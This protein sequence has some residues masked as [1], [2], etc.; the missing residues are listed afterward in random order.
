M[1]SNAPGA[2]PPAVVA[3]PV[4]INWQ[5]GGGAPAGPDWRRT[6]AAIWRY[7]W[8]IGLTTVVGV[9]AGIVAGQVMHPVYQA[10]ATIWID[11]GDPRNPGPAWAGRGDR[12]LGENAWSD[13][14]TSFAVLE[15]AVRSQRLY[16]SLKDPHDA[17]AFAAFDVTPDVRPGTYRLEVDDNGQSYTLATAEGAPLERGELGGPVGAR[18]GFSWAPVP[19]SVPAGH[20]IVFSV[21]T[22][23]D[24]AERL[25]AGLE[26]TQD[27]A[28]SF[29]R[30][31]LKGSSPT[32][33][34]STLNAVAQRFVE[35][36]DTLKRQR[37]TEVRKITEEQLAVAQGNLRSAEGALQDFQIKTT[38]LPGG[39][40][41]AGRRSDAAVGAEASSGFFNMQVEKEQLVRD[42]AAMA[43]YLASGAGRPD[44]TPDAQQLETIQSA[45][46]APALAQALTEL[47][48]KQAEL[49]AMGYRYL[50]DYP[51][52]K[53][54]AGDITELQRRTIPD[55]VRG[56]MRD[57]DARVAALGGQLGQ[58]AATLR[59]VPPRLIEAARLQRAVSIADDLYTSLEQRYQE[60]HLTENAAV[61]D[62]RVLDLAVAPQHPLRNT[63]P[64]LLFLGLVAGCGLG[65]VAAVVLDRM[66]G[67]MRRAEEVSGDLGLTILGTVPHLNRGH[68]RTI[69][70]AESVETIEA[71]RGLRVTLLQAFDRV[72]AMALT[73]TSPGPGDGKSFIS[74][75]L[76][77]ACA[78]SGLRTVL[79]DG[80]LR[81][82]TLFRQ[83][84]AQKGPGLADYL[85]GKVKYDEILQATSFPYLTFVARGQ[86][87]NDSPELLEST[88]MRHLIEDLKSRY[89]V[90]IC[91]SPPLGAG[92]DST[93]I[94]S[95]TGSLLLVVRTG[96]SARSVAQTSLEILR[97]LPIRLLGAVINDVPQGAA[98]RYYPYSLEYAVEPEPDE[99]PSRVQL[100]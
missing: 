69:K 70:G 56:V 26:V 12:L 87:G 98:Y 10:Q 40:T 77:L 75:N 94:G 35:V 9:L 53:R 38:T 50:D 67:R 71:L 16:L 74:T 36:A 66:D 3:I 25:G 91:D 100:V 92:V 49:R 2:P 97:R 65:L 90:V 54:L 41:G 13:L 5:Q 47:S 85:R 68:G 61:A 76:A 82:G 64:G 84:A 15:N 27:E 33:L 19:S 73:I 88:A 79:I 55:L 29:I 93:V 8:L 17:S 59:Q 96:R 45:R 83:L 31:A 39:G 14:L 60:A 20:S 11:Q 81:R 44:S 95:V 23:R 32:H 99:D 24:A 7:R 58:Q 28:G 62:V 52:K 89:D 30:V 6:F 22:P 21:S 4:A 72:G 1:P 51:P 46:Q 42:R 18:E 34:A 86:R 57:D 37:L 63:A 80:D 48:A 78:A 43:Q